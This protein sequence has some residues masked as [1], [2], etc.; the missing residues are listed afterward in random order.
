MWQYEKKLQFPVNIRKPDARAAKV[1]ISQL[2]GPDGE[3]AAALRYLSQRYTMPWTEMRA[4]LTDIG[5]EETTVHI[6]SVFISK[7]YAI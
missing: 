6:M 7:K 1:I 4:L 3:M 2:G 5:T